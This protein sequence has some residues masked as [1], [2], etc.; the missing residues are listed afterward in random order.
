V[1]HVTIRYVEG[2][3]CCGSTRNGIDWSPEGCAHGTPRDA[4]GHADRVQ[5]RLEWEA[6]DL[7]SPRAAVG[8]GDGV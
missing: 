5:R 7:V 6:T 8:D 3:H 4:I 1:I 2:K